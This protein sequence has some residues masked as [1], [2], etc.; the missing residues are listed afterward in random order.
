MTFGGHTHFSR[1]PHSNRIMPVLT[2]KIILLGV[3]LVAHWLRIRLPRQ[4]TRGRA[5]FRE[6]PTCFRATKPVCHNYWAC[7]LEPVHH[8][9]WA[10]ALEPTSHNYWSPYA[11]EPTLQLL[12]PAHSRACVLQLLSLSAATT[13]AHV[14]RARAPQREATA[15]RSPRTATKSSPRSPQL[16]KACAQQRRPKAAKKKSKQ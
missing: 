13:E 15:M 11:L 5:L 14:P 2:F 7:T 1:A 16:E 10:C 3:S 6:D 12:K 8:N 4:G 9:Y